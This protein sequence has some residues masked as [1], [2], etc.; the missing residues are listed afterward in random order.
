MAFSIVR[1]GLNRPILSYKRH[2]LIKY[3]PF[4]AKRGPE[5][6]F[7]KNIDSKIRKNHGKQ[8]PSVA[9]CPLSVHSNAVMIAKC[10]LECPRFSYQTVSVDTKIA[11]DRER[12]FLRWQRIK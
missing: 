6:T 7:G 2:E 8:F 9:L 11:L 10:L 12:E 4:A 5:A 3:K 1:N